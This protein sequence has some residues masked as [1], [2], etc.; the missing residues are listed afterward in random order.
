MRPLRS[1][2]WDS[3]TERRR[4]PDGLITNRRASGMAYSNE[5]GIRE[6]LVRKALFLI[7]I[8]PSKDEY[9]GAPV[10]N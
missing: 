5:S 9:S 10:I 4:E 2:H 7:A 1:S 8:A 3:M 6:E